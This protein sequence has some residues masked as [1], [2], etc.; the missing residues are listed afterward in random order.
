MERVPHGIVDVL[1][2]EIGFRVLSK[3][4]EAEK[5]LFILLTYYQHNILTGG[6]VSTWN[7]PYNFVQI[8]YASWDPL[9][10]SKFG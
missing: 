10:V 9:S 3:S 5:V 7:P 6:N 2:T 1:E 4:E 8:T